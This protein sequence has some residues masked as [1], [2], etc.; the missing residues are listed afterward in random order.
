MDNLQRQLM[1]TLLLSLQQAQHD[2]EPTERVVMLASEGLERRG[3]HGDGL[4][5]G[6]ELHKVGEAAGVSDA[7][8]GKLAGFNPPPN[9]SG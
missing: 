6:G 7:L 4:R 9:G 3:A 1:R 5:L 8:G 2:V